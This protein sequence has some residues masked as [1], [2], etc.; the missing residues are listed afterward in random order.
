M[1]RDLLGPPAAEATKNMAHGVAENAEQVAIL[2]TVSAAPRPRAPASSVPHRPRIMVMLSISISLE[3]ALD[4][5][6][7][8]HVSVATPPHFSG[9]EERDEGERSNARQQRF[10]GAT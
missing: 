8:G 7:Q 1:S 2:P 6:K 9:I 5:V 10:V 3:S 4:A